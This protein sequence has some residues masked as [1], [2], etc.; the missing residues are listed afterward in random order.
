M[1]PQPRRL[2]ISRPLLIA[3]PIAATLTVI[4]AIRAAALG[5]TLGVHLAP[6]F[7][8]HGPRLN[9]L[10]AAPPVV[11]LHLGAALTALGIGAVLLARIK[12]NAF[13]RV[14]G[15]TWVAA[16]G[17]VAV[18][19]LFI[20]Q[21]N[22]GSFSFLHLFSGWVVISLPAAVYAA[23]RHKTRLHARAMTGMFVGGLLIAGAFNFVPG[24]LMWAVFVG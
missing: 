14:L 23:R 17:T 16:M 20:R 6:A 19:S 21:V 24:R 15:W 2:S 5:P 4:A 18:S 3:A 10:W 13:H 7:H 9:L 8:W 1:K 11:L 12:G 22:H